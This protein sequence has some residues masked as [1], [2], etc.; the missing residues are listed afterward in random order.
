MTQLAFTVT[1]QKLIRFSHTGGSWLRLSSCSFKLYLA[2]RFGTWPRCFVGGEEA[3]RGGT[4][5]PQTLTQH[6][7]LRTFSSLACKSEPWS[8]L[9]LW[10]VS[11]PSLLFLLPLISSP[12]TGSK[13]KIHYSPGRL[14]ERDTKE[15][16]LWWS[17]ISNFPIQISTLSSEQIPFNPIIWESFLLSP[18]HRFVI[19]SG[20][21]FSEF[22]VSQIV[23]QAH[24]G[25]A[26]LMTVRW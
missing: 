23:G 5:R 4:S 15:Q 26:G 14:K 10:I 24:L 3:V 16:T 9:Q 20:A 2:E 7:G 22:T 17:T 8:K 12:P 21:L 25:G 13:W 18:C 19:Q 1:K 6:G 11:H